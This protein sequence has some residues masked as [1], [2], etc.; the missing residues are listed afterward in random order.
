MDQGISKNRESSKD[1]TILFGEKTGLTLITL[2]VGFS[3]PRTMKF[4]DWNIAF[5]Q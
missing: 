2:V 3:Q 4:L 1:P 5:A